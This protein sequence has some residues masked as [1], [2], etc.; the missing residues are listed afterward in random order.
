M[1]LFLFY[2]CFLRHIEF[3]HQDHFENNYYRVPPPNALSTLI[4]FFWETRFDPVWKKNEDKGF[5]DAQFPNLGYTYLINLGNPVAM[6]V[7]D[8]RQKLSTAGFLPR[9]HPIEAF[10]QPGDHLFGIK[11]RISPV[12][13]EKKVNFSEYRGYIFPLSYLMDARVI[14]AVKRKQPF[15]Q[16]VNLLSGYFISL[17]DRYENSMQPIH[18]VS[19]F[20]D[21][22][23]QE[24]D[25][26]ASL[27]TEAHKSGIS[28]RTFLRYFR[29]CT[30][31]SPKQA[32]QV[33]RIR[34]AIHGILSNPRKFDHRDFGYFDHSHFYKH[35][36][37]FLAQNTFNAKDLH[38]RV[39][40]LL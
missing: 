16:R 23:F 20:L 1:A 28:T 26:S 3:F 38:L 34:K 14:G 19:A 37:D 39:L 4:E 31:I 17:L 27:E 6:V 22:C 18:V 12:L 13:F 11:F 21:R 9:Y 15:D 36:R 7:E 32:L 25:F 30:G 8:Q 5:S 29:A 24:N 10:H 2:F 35:L 33:M 40:E